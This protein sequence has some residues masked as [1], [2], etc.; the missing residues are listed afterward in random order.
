M[1]SFTA[2]KL[3]EH[4]RDKGEI[5]CKEGPRHYSNLPMLVSSRPRLHLLQS[6]AVS[7]QRALTQ[8]EGLLKTQ[9][10]Q[11]PALCKPMIHEECEQ[12]GLL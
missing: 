7:C 5:I 11:Q 6:S 9:Q 12:H 8:M 3:L 4:I 10:V 1:I 2:S